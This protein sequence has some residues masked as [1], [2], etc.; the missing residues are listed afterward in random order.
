MSKPILTQAQGMGLVALAR[1]T[2]ENVLADKNNDLTIFD[3]DPYKIERG[4]FVT[5]FSGTKLRGCIGNIEPE[6]TLFELAQKLAIAAAT[7]DPR[8]KAVTAPELKNIELEVSILS[9]TLELIGKDSLEK[10]SQIRPFIDGIVIEKGSNKATFLPQ[11]WESLKTKEAFL[12]ELCKKACLEYDDWKTKETKI[13][14]YQVQ[15]FKEE[16]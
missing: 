7:C 15:H 10:T 11:V 9:P 12:G 1:M 5:L 3:L 6:G 8:F 13:Y 4:V 14:S 16:S 2:L